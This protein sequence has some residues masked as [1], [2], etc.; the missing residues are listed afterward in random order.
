MVLGNAANEHLLA[1]IRPFLS[2]FEVHVV[3]LQ[4]P[5]DVDR[6]YEFHPI[7]AVTGTRLDY[8]MAIPAVR[9]LVARIRPSFIHA[10]YATFYGF[11]GAL[12]GARCPKLLTVW[13]SDVLV[14][15]R[16]GW[17]PHKLVASV[18][19]SYDCVIAPAEHVRG[20]L[21]DLGAEPGR[22]HVFQYGVDLD[23]IPSPTARSSRRRLTVLS[24]RGWDVLYRIDEIVAGFEL[25]CDRATDLE[26][27]ITGSGSSADAH[28]VYERVQRSRCSRHVRVVGRVSRSE[29]LRILGDCDIV[30]SVP[31]SDATSLALLEGLAAGLFPIVS[32]LPGNREWIENG[33]GC[34]LKTVTPEAIAAGLATA[35]ERLRSGYDGA[36]N[37]NK[38]EAH[39][40]YARNVGRLRELYRGLLERAGGDAFQG[41]GH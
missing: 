15:P 20:C 32:D 22:I 1:W 11:W 28:R 5:S 23:S 33:D 21:L 7:R 6:R 4:R 13:G 37:R 34:F 38:V 9:S 24:P 41:A 10:H 19:R 2:D 27:M 39:A 25:Y 26:L 30:V 12:S 40:D 29:F 18:V 35:V 3:S 8:L 17:L 16:S 31:R 14:V 36:R